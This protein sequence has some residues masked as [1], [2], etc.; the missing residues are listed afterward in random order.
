MASR[1]AIIPRTGAKWRVKP[2]T[3]F[4]WWSQ[5]CKQPNTGPALWATGS[6][7]RLWAITTKKLETELPQWFQPFTERLTRGSSSS[8]DVSSADVAM[9]PPAILPSAHPPDQQESTIDSLICQSPEL[10][11][12][13]T[14]GSYSGAMQKSILTIGQTE[15]RLSKDL[16]IW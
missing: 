5:A 3:A 9:P 14:H 16:G 15:L 10:R 1:S 7:H 6:W 11:S 8:T 2:T 12:M 4:P 13:Q